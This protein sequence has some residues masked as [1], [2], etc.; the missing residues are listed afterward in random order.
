MLH[1]N[2]PQL[3]PVL[4]LLVSE[5][6]GARIPEATPDVRAGQAVRLALHLRAE[7]RNNLEP[8][9]TIRVRLAEKGIERSLVRILD[10][11]LWLSHPGAGI[12]GTVRAFECRLA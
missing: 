3:F 9:R 11:I 10:A 7:G 5:M 8:L 12:G 2:R 6:L 1:L 4:D